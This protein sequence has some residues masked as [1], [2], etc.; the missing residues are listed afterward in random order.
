MS[1]VHLQQ[2]R[3]GNRQKNTQSLT[4]GEETNAT[5]FL[6]VRIPH[7]FL[8]FGLWLFLAIILHSGNF[9]PNEI[10]YADCNKLTIKFVWINPHLAAASVIYI[11]ILKQ[12]T[13]FCS[14]LP[15]Q[16]SNTDQITQRIFSRTRNDLKNKSTSEVIY[17]ST[18]SFYVK[19]YITKFIRVRYLPSS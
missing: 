3:T 9:I 13:D 5:H 10:E 14:F 8:T 11:S 2:T 19:H 16:P 4:K 12:S 1:V 6:Q 15:F 7:Y 17:M 18:I